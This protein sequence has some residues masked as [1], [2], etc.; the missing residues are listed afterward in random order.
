MH[1]DWHWFYI[2]EC[3]PAWPTHLASTLFIRLQHYP[4][5][6]RRMPVQVCCRLLIILHTLAMPCPCLRLQFKLKLRLRLRLRLTLRSQVSDWM[7]AG[8]KQRAPFLFMA[9]VTATNTSVY[10]GSTVVKARVRTVHGL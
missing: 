6:I 3:S 1:W 4:R 8:H 7:L 9:V 2:K 10:S 5:R